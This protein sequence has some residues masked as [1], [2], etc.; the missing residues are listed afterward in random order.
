MQKNIS[1]F[2]ILT[3][4]LNPLITAAESTS[5]LQK[6][7]ADKNEEMSSLEQEIA[8]YQNQV[9][10]ISSQAQTLESVLKSI[11]A[12]QK[13]L[14]AKIQLT[15][16]RITQTNSTIAKNE[17]TIRKLSR[18]I[19]SN[20][21]AVEETIRSLNTMDQTSLL[22]VIMSDESISQ[23]MRKFIDLEKIQS[24]FKNQVVVMVDTKTS[25]IEAQKDLALK[26]LELKKLQSDLSDQER[27]IAIQ[28]KEQDDLLRETKNQESQYLAL[29][30]ERRARKLALDAEIQNYESQLTFT[31][32]TKSLPKAGS[33]VLGWPVFDPFITQRFGKTV[34]ARRLYVSG[35]HSGIDFRAPVGTPVYAVAD[36]IVEGVGDTD[37]T[38][39]RASFGKWVFIRHY[40]GLATAYGH[41]SL[42]KAVDG[43]RVVK[44]ELIG[45][46]GNT[47]H[48]TG[49]HLHLTV[50]AANGIDGSE[51]ARVANRPSASCSGKSYRMPIAPTTAYL[52]PL[53]YLPTLAANKF[54]DH[55]YE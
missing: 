5:F 54:K 9:N 46:S 33:K 52:D 21:S 41:L 4:C 12:N 24:Q 6:K 48:S 2:L 42:I 28:K 37:K 20:T 29:L 53:L 17:Q 1:T 38:C 49:P 39:Y 23:F 25:L 8:E 34:D 16:K 26:T 19:V 47:G 3:L 10:E 50:Y 13:Q 32:D 43:Q 14:Q 7:I 27:I 40:N 44:G 18:G 35:S 55:S 31:L 36:G 15:N 45:Y 51:G 30:Q 22:E 11:S